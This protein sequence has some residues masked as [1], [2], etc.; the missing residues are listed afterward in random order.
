[1]NCSIS[2]QNEQYFMIR[3]TDREEHSDMLGLSAR[4]KAPVHGI[5]HG[6]VDVMQAACQHDRHKQYWCNCLGHSS[7][8][9]G[10]NKN[11]EPPLQ[12]V[13]ESPPSPNPPNPPN[14]PASAPAPPNPPLA[15][16]C[17]SARFFAAA[18][19]LPPD[20]AILF[21]GT[22]PTEPAPQVQPLGLPYVS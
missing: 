16:Q 21:A 17:P 6:W 18:S 14:A 3:G 10:I 4:R 11:N 8:H 9:E 2:G 7:R 22:K 5:Q 20:P 13:F 1:M 19:A 12:F 15:A